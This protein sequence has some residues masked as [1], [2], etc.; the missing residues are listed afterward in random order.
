MGSYQTKNFCTG[1]KSV[2]K[3][4]DN[5][6]NGRKCLPQT[7]RL[8]SWVHI[9]IQLLSDFLLSIAILICPFLWLKFWKLIYRYRLRYEMQNINRYKR[10][11]ET[12]CDGE[13]WI[14]SHG[15][16]NTAK[17]NFEMNFEINL[18]LPREAMC[19]VRCKNM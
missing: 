3:G 7:F 11:S 4:K 1:N 2:N 9:I 16:G 10:R 12:I 13:V 17:L 19:K 8:S 15:D 14:Q 18:C 6:W 5:W